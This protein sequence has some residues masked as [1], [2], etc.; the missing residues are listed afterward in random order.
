G[1]LAAE[2]AALPVPAKPALK[3]RAKRRYVGKAWPRLDM[4]AKSDGSARFGLDSFAPGMLYGAVARPPAYGAKAGSYDEKAAL[5]VEGVRGVFPA[6]TGVGVVAD[7]LQAAWKGRDALAPRWTGGEP[8]FDDAALEALLRK[9]LAG[10][11]LKARDDGDAEG[12]L[13]GARS[14]IEAEYRLPYLSHVTME[15]MNCL[16]EVRADGCDVWAPTQ[17]QSGTQAAAA[18]E[19]GLPPGKVKVHTT[20][21]GGGF[22]RRFET[23]FVREAVQ[24]SKAA[25]RPVKVVWT[26]EDDMGHDFYRPGS[27]CRIRGGLDAKGRLTALA[28]KTTAASI[29]AR[30]FPAMLRGGVDNSAVEGV[31]DT[32]YAVADLRVEWARLEAPVPVGF[33]RSVGNSSNA[34]VMES[35]IDELA[36]AAGRDPLAFRLELLADKPRSRRLLRL[37]AHKAGWGRRLPKGRAL[38]LAHHASFGSLVA[39][40]AEVSVDRKTGAVRVHRLVCG[41]DCGPVV[42]VDTAKAQLEGASLM[43]LSGAL[44]EEMSFSAGGAATLNFDSYGLLRMDEAPEVEAFVVESEGPWGGLGEPGLPPAAPAV[45]NAVFRACG[46]RLRRLP[47]TPER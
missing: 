42:N 29:F 41:A 18:E 34:F 11:A 13:R 24:L 19:A 5:A 43:G 32:P 6:G 4:P 27:L 17:N 39:T 31:S 25:G 46:A 33:W 37:V 8:G 9:T 3:P 26:R 40:A 28:H 30:V 12:A 14:V 47:M 16:A 35:F 15:P 22:G 21:L 2:A 20:L 45:A 36:H 7:T 44:K 38:G 23:D 1:A 10:P